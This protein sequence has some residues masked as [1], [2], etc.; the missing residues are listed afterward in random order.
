MKVA[1]RFLKVSKELCT[2]S[3]LS[4]DFLPDDVL[5]EDFLPD[6]VLPAPELEPEQ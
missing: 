5:P 1:S 4:G 6:D 3:F 2:V